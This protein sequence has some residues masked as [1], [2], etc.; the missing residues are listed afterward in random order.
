LT[1]RLPEGTFTGE[2]TVAEKGA[3]GG[4]VA[5]FVEVGSVADED[6]LDGFGIRNHDDGNMEKVVE[7]DMP[8]FAGAS[9]RVAAPMADQLVGI[10]EGKHSLGSG[11]E[12]KGGDGRSGSHRFQFN[13]FVEKYRPGSERSLTGVGEGR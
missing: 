1:L 6:G 3:D 2:E 4:V 9:R 8:E 13:G 7:N 5:R 12:G 10:A 11:R